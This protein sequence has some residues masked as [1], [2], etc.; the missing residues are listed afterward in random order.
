MLLMRELSHPKTHRQGHC[1][2]INTNFED[3]RPRTTLG[4]SVRSDRRT[5]TPRGL[6][7][8]RDTLCGCVV[9]RRQHFG[10]ARDRRGTGNSHSAVILDECELPVTD[11]TESLIGPDSCS[12]AV[13]A[14]ALGV[15]NF[16]C[17]RLIRENAQFVAVDLTCPKIWFSEI[18]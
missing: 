13:I 1:V 3:C 17:V 9:V 10:V 11:E 4:K 14:I 2:T 12:P 15:N 5:D 16:L 18:A 6:R 7:P 8:S